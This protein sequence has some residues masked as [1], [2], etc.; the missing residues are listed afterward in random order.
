MGSVILIVSTVMQLT[1]C[2]D[3]RTVFSV[4]TFSLPLLLKVK[5]LKLLFVCDLCLAFRV[6][7]DA[8][9]RYSC[10]RLILWF[11]SVGYSPMFLNN[12]KA[13]SL[14]VFYYQRSYL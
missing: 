7:V 11:P 4:K 12:N 5:N 14:L 2:E 9:Q 1:C 8:T 10:R 13:S 6:H 3:R